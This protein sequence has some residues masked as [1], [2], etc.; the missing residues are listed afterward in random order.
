M[1]CYLESVADSKQ[2]VKGKECL[3]RRQE[4][5]KTSFAPRTG[6]LVISQGATSAQAEDTKGYVCVSAKGCSGAD[7]GA[8]MPA[9]GRQRRQRTR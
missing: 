5:A 2:S 8:R 7:C 9:Q 1:Q 3:K 6:S 4:K